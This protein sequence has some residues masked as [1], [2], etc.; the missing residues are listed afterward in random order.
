MLG[1]VLLWWER[2]NKVNLHQKALREM[3]GFGTSSSVISYSG[4]EKVMSEAQTNAAQH[5]HAIEGTEKPRRD[6]Q[7][8][9][10]HQK[11]HI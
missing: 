9:W 7:R 8:I 11:R 3:F 5:R 10:K 6:L 1:G 2:C 4:G